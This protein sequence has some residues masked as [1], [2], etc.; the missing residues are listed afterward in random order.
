V[1]DQDERWARARR[2]RLRVAID[3]VLVDADTAEFQL[4]DEFARRIAARSQKKGPH[5][6]KKIVVREHEFALLC[7]LSE[8]D[9]H[10]AGPPIEHGAGIHRGER[11]GLSQPVACLRWGMIRGKA[12][13][14]C[15]RRLASG[16][17]RPEVQI[18]MRRIKHHFRCGVKTN[19]EGKS[20]VG[21]VGR[22]A[23]PKRQF[24]SCGSAPDPLHFVVRNLSGS[25][26]KAPLALSLRL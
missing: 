23:C 7:S 10:A 9:R 15:L 19:C 11:I 20:P 5:S 25:W 1:L 8:R 13:G 14:L 17:E 12:L 3:V 16:K 2:K 4:R 21:N 24:P 6:A 18:Q 26:I 22:V